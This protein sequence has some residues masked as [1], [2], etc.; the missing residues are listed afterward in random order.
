MKTPDLLNGIRESDGAYRVELSLYQR[1]HGTPRWPSCLACLAMMLP[2]CCLFL[3][4]PR[5]TFGRG[6]AREGSKRLIKEQTESPQN[7]IRVAYW[8]KGANLSTSNI[9]KPNEM[10]DFAKKICWWIRFIFI[11]GKASGSQASKRCLVP[12]PSRIS[13][14]GMSSP[15]PGFAKLYATRM[16]MLSF[17]SFM[18]ALLRSLR[19]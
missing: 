10:I 8:N 4:I 17:N 7:W 2:W 19:A 14:E 3:P 18:F 5:V 13:S 11:L 16:F 6:L 12:S 9:L 1:S 15:I